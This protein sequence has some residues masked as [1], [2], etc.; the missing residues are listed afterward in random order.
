MTLKIPFVAC[1]AVLVVLD[2]V[3]LGLIMRDFYQENIGHLFAENISWF[4]GIIFYVFY[5]AGVFI[6]AVLPAVRVGKLRRAVTLGALLGLL[7]YGTYDLTN[8]T[9]LKDWPFIV[10]VVDMLWGTFVTA[11]VSSVGFLLVRA[12]NKQKP[13]G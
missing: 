10:T 7:A 5:V 3:W 12:Y 6:F 9:T 13:V 8:Q 1:V 11:V 4:F 2:L